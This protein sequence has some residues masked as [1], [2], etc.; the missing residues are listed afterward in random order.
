LRTRRHRG[1]VSDRRRRQRLIAS[2][3]VGDRSGFPHRLFASP[4]KKPF[5]NHNRCKTGAVSL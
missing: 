4:G 5:V 2:H 3:D 1:V